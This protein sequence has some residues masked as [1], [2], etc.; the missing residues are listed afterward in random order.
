LILDRVWRIGSDRDIFG[1]Y[2]I[3]SA[4]DDANDDHWIPRL[5][6]HTPVA[7]NTRVDITTLSRHVGR[8]RKPIRQ[9]KIP[10][11]KGSSGKALTGFFQKLFN[12]T[13]PYQHPPDAPPAEE[14]K[15]LIQPANVIDAILQYPGG[16]GPG[17]DGIHISMLKAAIEREPD[18]N[19]SSKFGKPNLKSPLM[20]LLAQIFSDLITQGLFPES[21]NCTVIL[22]LPKK[23]DD[24]IET[25]ADFRPITL[26]QI[27]RRIF[28][29]CFLNLFRGHPGYKTHHTQAGFK[30]N[31]SCYTHVLAAM[32]Q[33]T[34]SAEEWIDVCLDI[35]KAY[36]TVV[37]SRL[38]ILL[39]CA[40][41]PENWIRC[42]QA[43]FE[44]IPTRVSY[45]GGMSSPFTRTNGILQGSILGPPLFIIYM[46][47]LATTLHACRPER[48][49]LFADDTRIHG[50][51]KECLV[52]LITIVE[53]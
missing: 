5:P 13:N 4:G 30:S 34:Q 42:L 27:V 28:E 33:E 9:P 2:Y 35:T 36:D 45:R 48:T 22:A 51:R 11:A 1:G 6:S 32:E 16:K 18:L 10:G 23:S 41:F 50:L 53:Q 3:D 47:T 19:N 52:E 37:L 43:L 39:R 14:V 12:T 44:N 46:D 7:P 21:L 20:V 24:Q 49:Y 26:T 25:A 17:P 31:Y 15:T 8:N 40:R 29:K 38:W